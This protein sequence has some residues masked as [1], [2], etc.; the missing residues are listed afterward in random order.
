MYTHEIYKC[1]GA[2]DHLGLQLLA[3]T[4]NTSLE[5]PLLSLRRKG[6]QRLSVSYSIVKDLVSTHRTN[7]AMMSVRSLVT[8]HTPKSCSLATGSFDGQPEE[9]FNG[10]FLRESVRPSQSSWFQTYFMQWH[11]GFPVL[12]EAWYK[13]TTWG[14]KKC[15]LLQQV[16]LSLQKNSWHIFQQAPDTMVQGP[17]PS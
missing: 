13:G 10:Y 3:G 11:R 4:V 14:E 8:Q 6:L 2:N 5:F 9:L 7:C 12:R 16:I 17:T 1:L 15:I